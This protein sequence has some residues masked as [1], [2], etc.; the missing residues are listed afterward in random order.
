V[1]A[2]ELAFFSS[3]ELVDELTRRQSFLG[4]ILHAV[5]ETRGRGWTGDRD[6]QVRFNDQNFSLE[7]A[8]RLLGEVASRMGTGEG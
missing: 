1:P 8:C 4:V 5:G 2:S 6:F 3:A 7:Q